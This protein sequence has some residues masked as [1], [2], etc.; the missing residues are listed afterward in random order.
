[1]FLKKLINPIVCIIL[2]SVVFGC[3]S[4]SKPKPEIKAKKEVKTPKKISTLPHKANQQSH[5]QGVIPI[6]PINNL[7]HQV[8]LN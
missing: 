6:K 8:N 5:F 7:E 3:T 2:I 4:S 1:M